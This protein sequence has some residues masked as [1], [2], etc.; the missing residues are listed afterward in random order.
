MVT[1]AH[2][3]YTGANATL[4]ENID[5]D[6]VLWPINKEDVSSMLNE[7]RN[8]PLKD[9]DKIWVTGKSITIIPLA[10]TSDDDVIV[11][12][13]PVLAGKTWEELYPVGN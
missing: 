5:A 4:Y 10:Y 7:A 1:V 3:G 6:I 8:V 13:A 11:F 12:K 9:A 2:H